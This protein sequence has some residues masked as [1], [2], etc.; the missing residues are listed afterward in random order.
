MVRSVSVILF[1]ALLLV[2]CSDYQKLLKSKDA[3]AKYAAAKEYF[4][5][6]K[7]AKSAALLDNLG[8]YY[9]GTRE[10]QEILYML[11]E[12]YVGRKDYYSGLEHYKIYVKNYPQ[13]DHAEDCMFMKGFCGYKLS[14]DARLEQQYTLDAIAAFEDYLVAFPSG[15]HAAECRSYTEELQEKLAYKDYLNARTYYNLGIYLGNNYRSC[16]IVA[17]EALRKFP[18]TKYRDDL[19]YLILSSK[20]K[21]AIYSV[22]ERKAERWREV[23]DEYYNYT[24]E[25]P[26]GRYLKDAKRYLK[27]ANGY[28]DKLN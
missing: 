17:E 11:A 27:E 3:E 6:G 20:Y 4:E 5:A 13:G 2:S 23:V 1:C 8:Q 25:F 10:A 15:K 9:R 28:L 22:D 16:I 21:E 24:N 12:S 7:F 14:P 26:D 19:F 18:E